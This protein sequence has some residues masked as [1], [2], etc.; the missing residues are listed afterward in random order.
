DEEFRGPV[1]ARHVLEKSINIPT[2]RL[3]EQVGIGFIRDIIARAGIESRLPAVPSLSLG[4]VEVTPLELAE[5]FTT[6]A[7]VGQ[8]CELRPLL[9]VYDSAGNLL[10]ETEPTKT[11]ALPPEPV[12][13]TLSLMRGVFTHGTG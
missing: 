10:V 9:E 11:E 1:H 12:Y 6:L 4:G 2:A 3:A 8:R 13:Q 5:A 7:N